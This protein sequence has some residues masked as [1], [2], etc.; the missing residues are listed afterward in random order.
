M[1]ISDDKFE[2]NGRKDIDTLGILQIFV[3]NGRKIS[4]K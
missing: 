2:V 3:G 4:K 1:M